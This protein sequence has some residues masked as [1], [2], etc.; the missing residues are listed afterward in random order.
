MEKSL[1]NLKLSLENIDRLR[2]RILNVIIIPFWPRTI[3][4]NHL[5]VVRIIISIS[6][7]FLL[8]YYRNDNGALIISLFFVGIITDL[9]DGSVARAL[10]K[11]T[12]LGIVLD[13]IADRM[14]IIP[15]AIYSLLKSYSKLLYVLLIVEIINAFISFYLRNNHPIIQPNIFG[16][17]KM[18][19]HSIVFLAILVYWPTTPNLF[20]ISILWVSIMFGGIGIFLKIK[21]AH[22]AT[23][24]KN[25]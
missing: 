12:K 1:Q 11:E 9:F 17:I 14:L 2:D 21:E 8:F 3:S 10:H 6:L 18:V 4:P 20:F 16:K 23:Q 13:P 22:A 25:L 7:F 5:T 19:L 24:G 15:I